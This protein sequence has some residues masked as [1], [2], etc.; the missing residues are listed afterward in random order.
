LEKNG[1]IKERP[2]GLA[3]GDAPGG[4]YRLV[5]C[6]VRAAGFLCA[7]FVHFAGKTVA[8]AHFAPLNDA[9]LRS[10]SGIEFVPRT[11]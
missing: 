8:L 3:P 6:I 7:G 11:L 10:F 4:K 2:E 5:G 9:S 1:E